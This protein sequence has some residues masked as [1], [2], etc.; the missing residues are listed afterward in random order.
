MPLRVKSTA[1]FQS[2]SE[3][4]LRMYF[5]A[6]QSY[7]RLYFNATQSYLRLYFIHKTLIINMILDLG[8]EATNLIHM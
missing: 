1:V 5:N 2:D 6:T 4:N 3:L 7:L 8:L